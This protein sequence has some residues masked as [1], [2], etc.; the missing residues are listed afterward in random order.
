[1]TAVQMPQSSTLDPENQHPRPDPL[2]PSLPPFLLLRPL[3]FPFLVCFFFQTISS[4]LG[5][6]PGTPSLHRTRPRIMLVQY[7][8]RLDMGLPIRSSEKRM[9]PTLSALNFGYRRTLSHVNRDRTRRWDHLPPITGN[10]YISA[11]RRTSVKTSYSVPPNHTSLPR[12]SRHICTSS[13]ATH[14]SLLPFP[15]SGLCK[16]GYSFPLSAA[17]LGPF[18]TPSPLHRLPSSQSI[19]FVFLPTTD[20]GS[21]TPP[22]PSRL[23]RYHYLLLTVCCLRFAVSR[24]LFAVAR[25]PFS[26][27]CY[28]PSAVCC[29]LFAKEPPPPHRRI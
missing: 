14:N 19:Q 25:L 6:F 7:Q 3:P 10:N 28:L 5:C 21:S 27:A 26:A 24:L 8:L 12:H 18:R 23:Y 29:L 16:K 13:A 22:A 20:D 2:R 9:L 17:P 4:S 11:V 1:M 15:Q